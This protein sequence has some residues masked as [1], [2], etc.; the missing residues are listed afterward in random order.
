MPRPKAFNPDNALDAA[1][2]VFWDKG[3]E[4][5][6][7]QDLTQAMGINRFSMYDTFGDKHA[8]YLRA[9]D[10]YAETVVRDQLDTLDRLSSLDELE[11]YFLRI[12]P[13]ESCPDT[14]TGSPCGCLL[15][16][17][18]VESAAHD[19]GACQRVERVRE[20][21]HQGFQSVLK[22]ARKAGELAPGVRIPDAAWAL[23][24]LQGGLATFGGAPLPPTAIR[25][26]I[27]AT[28]APL[29]AS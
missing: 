12:A 28:I 17:A 4:G 6:S 14:E 19:E 9:L 15:Q 22:R 24:V 20:S 29:R 13:P 25:S 10:R 3:F 2:A 27:R 18:M 1:M 21:L 23:F 7:V 8:L 5:A 16:R 26:A 11:R